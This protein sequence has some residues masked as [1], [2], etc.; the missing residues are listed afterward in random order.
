ML[1][2]PVRF[3][4]SEALEAM[5]ALPINLSVYTGLSASHWLVCLQQPVCLTLTAMVRIPHLFTAIELKQ[6]EIWSDCS[7]VLTPPST[8]VTTEAMVIA[9]SGLYLSAYTGLSTIPIRYTI[10]K[11]II[12]RTIQINKQTELFKFIES[13]YKSFRKN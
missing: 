3:V 13:N 2:L 9:Y 6:K 4:G 1:R 8:L 12:P 7:I 10:K 5:V 11:E